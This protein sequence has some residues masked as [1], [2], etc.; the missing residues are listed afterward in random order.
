MSQRKSNWMEAIWAVASCF[1]VCATVYTTTG[2]WQATGVTGL[3]AL[4]LKLPI[5]RIYAALRLQYDDDDDE[6]E[7]V[8]L[9]ETKEHQMRIVS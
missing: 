7:R 2:M 4:L 8:Q 1:I 6:S 5:S 3:V 9:G